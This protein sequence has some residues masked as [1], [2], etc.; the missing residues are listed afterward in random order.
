[1]KKVRFLSA[2]AA[3]LLSVSVVLSGCAQDGQQEERSSD[4]S[5]EEQ[6]PDTGRDPTAGVTEIR[7]MTVMELVHDMGQGINLG[8]TLEACGD[9]INPGGGVRGYETAWGSP[10]IT[11]KVIQG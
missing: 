4:S 10:V 5:Q 11:E 7:D 1:M 3:L 6:T 9:W 8:N 2:L